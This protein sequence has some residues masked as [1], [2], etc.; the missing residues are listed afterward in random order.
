MV[1]FVG[2]EV[3]NEYTSMPQ[4]LS[5]DVTQDISNGKIDRV[6]DFT[7]PELSQLCSVGGYNDGYGCSTFWKIFCM[8]ESHQHFTVNAEQ[9]LT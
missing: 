9:R 7:L 2:G 3:T 6:C 1:E 8:L 4:G 5:S